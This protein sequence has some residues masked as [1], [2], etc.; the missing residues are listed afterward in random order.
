MR[1]VRRHSNGVV[2]ATFAAAFI[3]G[4]SAF[5]AM[6]H[7]VAA[8]GTALPA[9]AL[10][11]TSATPRQAS[12]PTTPSYSGSKTSHSMRCGPCR[13]GRPAGDRDA[14][15]RRPGHATESP[16]FRL[17][18][19]HHSSVHIPQRYGARISEELLGTMQLIDLW[20]K[21]GHVVASAVHQPTQSGG[22]GDR[23]EWICD[24]EP[25][26]GGPTSRR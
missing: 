16:A 10:T 19:V 17:D 21:L 22:A 12:W 20:K 9:P 4:V 6:N 3:L 11:V 8:A 5:V 2:Y 25:A 18:S 15:G 23:E 14:P 1:P 13:D 7:R 24:G 26:L